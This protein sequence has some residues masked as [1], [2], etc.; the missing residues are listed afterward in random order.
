MTPPACRGGKIAGIRLNVEALPMLEKKNRP[1]INPRNQGNSP[2]DCRLVNNGMA[3]AQARS[4]RPLQVVT[5][6]HPTDH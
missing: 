2:S 4:P 3:T 5:M 1:S 6:A